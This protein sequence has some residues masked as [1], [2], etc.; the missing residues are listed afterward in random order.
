MAGIPLNAR[1]KNK[2]LQW[3]RGNTYVAPVSLVLSG[4]QSVTQS[5]STLTV[6]A[7]TVSQSI[8][9]ASS[10]LTYGALIVSQSQAQSTAMAVLDRKSVV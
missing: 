7:Q 6:L 9:Q 1:L 10:S 8:G 2:R 4:G 3:I 5:V